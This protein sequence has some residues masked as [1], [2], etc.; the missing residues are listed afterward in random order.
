MEGGRQ[1]TPKLWFGALGCFVLAGTTG[2]LFRF[3]LLY[4]LPAGLSFINVRHAHS[5]LMYFGWVTPALMALVGTHLARQSGYTRAHFSRV[6]IVV[7]GLALLAYVPFLLYGYQPAPVGGGRMP[8]ASIAAALNIVAW[9]AFVIRYAQVTRGRP[10]PLPVRL[11]DAALAFL[12]LASLGAWG[13]AVLVTLRVD[14]PFWEAVLVHLFLDLFSDGWFVL[15]LL[16]VAYALLPGP[17]PDAARWATWLVV[18]GLPATFL[19]GVPLSLVPPV[20]RWVAGAA[21]V[22][23][24]L[25][26]L[27][28]IVLLWPRLGRGWQ[29]PLAFLALKAV[30]GL[31]DSLPSVAAWAEAN[32]LRIPY[33]H[34]LLLGF[35]TLGLV[36]AAARTWGESAVRGRRGFTWGVLAV[37]ASLLPLTGLWPPVLTGRWV[38]LGAAWMALLPVGAA[39][40][41]LGHGLGRSA[42]IAVEEFA[43]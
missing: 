27:W 9:Y 12:V 10:R 30:G 21:G 19:L 36:E 15:G 5:H 29:I 13:R 43:R 33:L 18:V 40:F 6:V 14:D 26:L 1:P 25:G 37:Q 28:H 31:G 23:V 38:F 7:V 4:G 20:A 16:G 35:V 17:S 32:G 42:E 41:M 39:A 2:T 34:W 3:G 11:W 24:G 22:L 8:L